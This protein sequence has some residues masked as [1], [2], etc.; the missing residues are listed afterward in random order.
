LLGKGEELGGPKDFHDGGAPYHA[1]EE[2]VKKLEQAEDE[3]L[4]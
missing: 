4:R 2:G 3:R 1:A